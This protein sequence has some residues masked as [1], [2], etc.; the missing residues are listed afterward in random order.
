MMKVK[1]LI[2]ELK[3]F[4]GEADVSLVDSEDICVSWI[5]ESENQPKKESLQVFIEP[6][7]FYD[8]DECE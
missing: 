1:D 3:E 4:D 8:G 2:D 5:C 7:D 6:N